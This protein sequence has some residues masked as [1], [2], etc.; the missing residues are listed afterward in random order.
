MTSRIKCKTPGC[1]FKAKSRA[2]LFTHTRRKHILASS[3][4]PGVN[5]GNVNQMALT[6]VERPTKFHWRIVDRASKV[7]LLSHM[8][9]GH[10]VGKVEEDISYDSESRVCKASTLIGS[11]PQSLGIFIGT[12]SAQQAVESAI[13][14]L[15]FT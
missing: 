3:E 11:C 14:Y 13:D 7:W 2:G 8:R 12:H 1:D 6:P 4:A 5:Q 9:T 10:I 15:T